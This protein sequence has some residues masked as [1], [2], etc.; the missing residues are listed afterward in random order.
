MTSF[1]IFWMIM[2]GS[3]AITL[4]VLNLLYS[5]FGANLGLKGF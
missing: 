5:I 2:F 1:L 3:L 4:A